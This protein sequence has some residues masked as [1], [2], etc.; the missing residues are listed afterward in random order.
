MALEKI[1]YMISK[2]IPGFVALFPFHAKLSNA[3]GNKDAIFYP[4]KEIE[5]MSS[6]CDTL[7]KILEGLCKDCYK[8]Y[9]NGEQISFKYDTYAL[10]SFNA[11][12]VTLIGYNDTLNNGSFLILNSWGENWGNKGMMWIPYDYFL[13]YSRTLLFFNTNNDRDIN[14]EQEKISLNIDKVNVIPRMFQDELNVTDLDFNW[15]ANF[16]IL[17]FLGNFDSDF[18][19]KDKKKFVGDNSVEFIGN[20]INDK[21][22]DGKLI[23][24]SKKYVSAYWGGEFKKPIEYYSTY[25]DDGFC[26]YEGGFLN[27]EFHGKGI[28]LEID[29]SISFEGNF[30]NGV[31]NGFG[32]D[33]DLYDWNKTGKY[34]EGQ[35]LNSYWNGSGI[36]YFP[37]SGKI[38]YEGNFL[39]N[40]F[41]GY[42]ILYKESGEVEYEGE[43]LD[44]TPK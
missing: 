29:G 14:D 30:I 37:E 2:D 44:G 31:R 34:Y 41:H 11:H 21:P 20:F 7:T 32:I 4:D 9:F 19:S 27:D 22:S 24:P 8:R 13:E 10:P 42:G 1:K 40:Q 25:F 12:S 33:Y 17:N 39:N 6:G 28:Y 38:N 15:Q 26:L 18:L 36:L 35:F 23:F 16:P 43:F 3:G 5:C